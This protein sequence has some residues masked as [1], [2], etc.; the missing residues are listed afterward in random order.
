MIIPTETVYLSGPMSGLAKLNRDNFYRVEKH[1]KKIYKCNVWNPAK[2]PEGLTYEDYMRQDIAA[3]VNADIIVMLVGW[4][5][6]RGAK[7]ELQVATVC[8][9]RIIQEQSLMDMR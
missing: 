1:L 3:L 7:V 8:G 2:L 4:R 6:S 9:L 5:Q